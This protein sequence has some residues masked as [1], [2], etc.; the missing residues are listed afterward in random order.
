[1]HHDM[2]A[3]FTRL[4][5][6]RAPLL[7]TNYIL[8]ETTSR[9]R[10]DHGLVVA[11]RFLVQVEEAQAVRRLRVAWI[12]QRAHEDAWRVLRTNRTLPLSF[13]DAT[14]VVV[15]RANRVDRIVTLDRSFSSIGFQR[16]PVPVGEP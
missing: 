7:T 16:L 13:T 12:D 11:L 6:E 3:L 9:L 15:A 5:T 4:A 1:M 8:D 14:T 2:V 10:Y